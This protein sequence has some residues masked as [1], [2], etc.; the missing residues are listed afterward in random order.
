MTRL[1]R[2]LLWI[3]AGAAVFGIVRGI[4]EKGKDSGAG[5]VRWQPNET[6]LA[7]ARK[8]GKPILYDFTAE[9]CAPCHVL[10]HEG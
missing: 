5:L 7:A 9:W 8:T 2:A 1:S 4:M 6:A 3:L 10:D